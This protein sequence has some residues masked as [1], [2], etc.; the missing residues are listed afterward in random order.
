MDS[1]AGWTYLIDE[2][3]VGKLCSKHNARDGEDVLRAGEAV[4]RVPNDKEDEREEPEGKTEESVRGK[5]R[6][7]LIK[8]LSLQPN[9]PSFQS[10][11]KSLDARHSR[12]AA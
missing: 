2:L 7:P 1:H 10:T 5:G 9:S 8:P 6:W 12:L 4:P 3:D 11:G